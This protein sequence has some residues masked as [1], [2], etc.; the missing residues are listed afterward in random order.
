MR[1]RVC[2]CESEREKAR[3]IRE[4]RAMKIHWLMHGQ[5]LKMLWKW[6]DDRESFNKLILNAIKK[7]ERHYWYLLPKKHSIYTW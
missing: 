2:V 7:D 1:E 4:T 3:E 5:I 6:E